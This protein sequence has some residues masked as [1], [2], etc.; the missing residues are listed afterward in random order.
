MYQTRKWVLSSL[1]CAT[2]ILP[3]A[4]WVERV[5]SQEKYPT[6]SID[7][8]VPY[9]AGGGT[10]LVNRVM[11]AYLK[12]KWGVPVNV[13]NKPGGNTVPACVEVYNA[14]PDGYTLLGDSTGSA[15]MLPI[16]VQ[17]L[18]FKIIDRTFIATMSFLPLVFIVPSASQ[19]KTLKD[20]EAEAK[21]DPDNFTWAS[22]A[23][24]GLG[25]FGSRQFF[26]AIGVDVTRTKPI[27]GKGGSEL[28][29]L[30]AGGHI[31]FGNGTTPACL[32]AIKGGKVK[33]VATTSK[34]RWPDL[35]EVPTT[36]EQGYP[37]VNAQSYYGPSGPANL[38]SYIVEIWNRAL[39]EMVKDPEV[40][41]RMRNVGALP[42]YLNAHATKEYVVKE[43][44]EV[45]V[46][47]GL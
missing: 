28:V 35:P 37:T 27:M 1:L 5:Q 9:A 30:T 32:P 22:N 31:K 4:G 16:V 25:D 18:P 13:V 6:R 26:K 15:S 43:T 20:H 33:G 12:K 24:A 34:S 19:L 46:L 29:V 38:P 41:S 2:I 39:Q 14:K 47:W 45:R 7:I 44:E 10:D 36:A 3:L 11:A 42:S 21:R 40:I 17:N 23:G 8:F